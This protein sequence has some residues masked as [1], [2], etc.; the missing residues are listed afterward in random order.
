MPHNA[1]E[2]W[3]RQHPDLK[4][5]VGVAVDGS[6]IGDKALAVAAAFYREKRADRVRR[7]TRSAAVGTLGTR[8]ADTG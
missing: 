2:E 5:V 8:R 1:E 7:A 3:N 6:A 4:L